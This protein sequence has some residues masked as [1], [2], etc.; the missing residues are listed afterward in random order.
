MAL[1]DNM[2][3]EMGS[4]PPD[5]PA[6]SSQPGAQDPALAGV[7]P[8]QTIVPGDF[9]PGMAGLV[10]MPGAAASPPFPELKPEDEE[11]DKKGQPGTMDLFRASLIALSANL[12]P[13]VGLRFLA[14]QQHHLLLLYTQ[15]EQGT[16][17]PR[18][19]PEVQFSMYLEDATTRDALDDVKRPDGQRH[20]NF[21]A[22]H[23]EG[24]LPMVQ[25]ETDAYREE[26]ADNLRKS[27]ARK[28]KALGVPEAKIQ[29][30]LA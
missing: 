27:W 18:Y 28:L 9:P 25:A 19:T 14:W 11:Q 2:D 15:D 21:G 1:D 8:A 7:D 23:M 12:S 22:L 16:W 6:F 20:Y 10:P 3:R 26:I 5:D 30:A 24:L 13:G 29:Q 17:T 4:H